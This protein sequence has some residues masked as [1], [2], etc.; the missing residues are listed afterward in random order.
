MNRQRCVEVR[1]SLLL[2]RASLHTHTHTNKASLLA[3]VESFHRTESSL[4]RE[5]V[6]KGSLGKQ[7]Y[8]RLPVKL[9]QC[10]SSVDADVH[11]EECVTCSSV[12]SHL[13][14]VCVCVCLQFSVILRLSFLLSL[15]PVPTLLLRI[16][17][18]S[19]LARNCAASLKPPSVREESLTHRRT[20]AHQ[21]S[22]N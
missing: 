6:L 11:E 7:K 4:Q 19:G 2:S 14:Q 18:C 10:S 15:Y 1:C 21:F 16:D 8:C 5:K 17:P 9:S 20:G 12:G 13:L 3:S 22:P